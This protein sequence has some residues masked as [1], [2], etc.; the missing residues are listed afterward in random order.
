MFEEKRGNRYTTQ[1]NYKE[2]SWI[3][4]PKHSFGRGHFKG[5]N[6]E[7]NFRLLV[8]NDRRQGRI[9]AI[10]PNPDIRNN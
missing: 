9:S 1:I 7:Y 3:K 6:Q 2:C 4:E 8:N 10:G 5:Y